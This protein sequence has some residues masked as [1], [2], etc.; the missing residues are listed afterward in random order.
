MVDSFES[1]E[2]ARLPNER[3]SDRRSSS[4]WI[5]GDGFRD[6]CSTHVCEDSNRCRMDPTTVQTG[7]CVFV[8]SDLFQMFLLNVHPN[9]V[10]PYVLVSHNGDLSTPDG[11]TDAPRLGFAHYET[12]PI[13]QKA[14]EEG[15]IIA[16]HGQNLWW[17][18]ETIGGP[19]PAFLHCLPIGF[20]NRLY[21]VG[22]NPQVYADMIRQNVL[23]KAMRSMDELDKR[24]LLFIAFYPK[25][26]IPDR[27]KV[28]D[29][30]GVYKPSPNKEAR[31]YNHT[32]VDHQGWL[33]GIWHHKFTLAPFGHGLDTHRLSEI[34]L[35]GGIP[36]IKQSSIT[37]CYDDTDNDMGSSLPPRKSLPLVIL[38]SWNELT[39]EKLDAEWERIKAVPSEQ[40]DHTRLLLDHWTTRI[41]NLG[42]GK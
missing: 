22:R 19:R 41:K 3:G 14:H 34:L 12:L 10:N 24:P 38:K 30:L 36:V 35:M 25:G 42:T 23:N 9:I 26:R 37:S 13:L 28:L 39:K 15:K 8:K 40:W 18:N 31:W 27:A 4:P 20:E 17:R 29:F 33:D 2:K 16:H 32:D 6:F 1:A 7:G 11:Q 5:T 21:K